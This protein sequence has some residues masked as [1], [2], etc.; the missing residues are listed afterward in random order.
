MVEDLDSSCNVGID[1]LCRILWSLLDLLILSP[2]KIFG[3]GI[4]L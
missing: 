2:I 3:L 4:L 1:L